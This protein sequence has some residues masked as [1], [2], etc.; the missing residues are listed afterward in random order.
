MSDCIG[1][2]LFDFAWFKK[3]RCALQDKR[4]ARI[5]V[6]QRSRGSVFIAN[7]RAACMQLDDM[8][9]TNKVAVQHLDKPIGRIRRKPPASSLF[10]T[11]LLSQEDRTVIGRGKKEEGAKNAQEELLTDWMDLF[12]FFTCCDCVDRGFPEGE[13]GSAKKSKREEEGRLTKIPSPME[14]YNVAIKRRDETRRRRKQEERNANVGVSRPFSRTDYL[15]HSE[16]PYRNLAWKAAKTWLV[17][18]KKKVIC[19]GEGEKHP[20]G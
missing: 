11:P 8:S 18:S 9:A 20:E 6:T 15:A 4:Y 10:D 3:R 14:K 19:R 17:K 5:V 12:F 1:N 13:G 2:G 16:G 7:G